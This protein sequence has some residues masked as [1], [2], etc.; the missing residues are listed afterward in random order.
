MFKEDGTS[1]NLYC[2]S[3]LF[4]GDGTVAP[5]APY[6]STD[7]FIGSP[8]RTFLDPCLVTDDLYRRREF[9]D[10]PWVAMGLT[11]QSFCGGTTLT[12]IDTRGR[13]RCDVRSDRPALHDMVC[14]KAAE[15]GR[16]EYCVQ[17]DN[18]AQA[19]Q[20]A[21]RPH[22]AYFSSLGNRELAGRLPPGPGEPGVPYYC[23]GVPD[24]Q[25]VTPPNAMTMSCTVPPPIVAGG[26]PAYDPG[27]VPEGIELDLLST[28]TLQINNGTASVTI[29][30]TG[31]VAALFQEGATSFV[32]SNL[33]VRQVGSA[34]LNGLTLADGQMRMEDIWVGSFQTAASP[35][36]NVV[37]DSA[38]SQIQYS[39]GGPST[40]AGCARALIR[41]GRAAATSCTSRCPLPTRVRA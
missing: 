19:I 36:I 24:S 35:Q 37:R 25:I 39:Y 23:F 6:Q 21:A 9:Q 34:T 41:R 38:L 32:L 20:R 4:L 40:T 22:F 18:Q 5:S 27:T 17:A 12:P 8:G 28:S 13:Y 7:P 31:M 14:P 2:E 3:P 10:P 26:P 11:R 30:V 15:L 33:R 16:P 1:Q 29:P